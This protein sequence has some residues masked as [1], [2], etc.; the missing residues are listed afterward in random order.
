MQSQSVSSGAS[1]TELKEE[2]LQIELEKAPGVIFSIRSRTPGD[3]GLLAC[4]Q[5]F[6]RAY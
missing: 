3:F 2:A 1:G 5:T 6:A 4:F